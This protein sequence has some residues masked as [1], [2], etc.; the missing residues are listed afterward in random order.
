MKRFFL[1]TAFIL[2]GNIVFAQNTKISILDH[3]TA[4]VSYKHSL[5]STDM[6]RTNLVLD[7]YAGYKFKN[8][9]SVGPVLSQNFMLN[10]IEQTYK[11]Q[12][13]LGLGIRY[14]IFELERNNGK[15]SVEPY[16]NLLRDTENNNFTYYDAGVNF[17]LPAA[18][19]CFIGIGI[20]HYFYDNGQKNHFTSY[21][22]IGIRL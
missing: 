6:S 13:C 12:A 22:S 8:K 19:N 9:I 2:L 16:I 20:M 4:N 7:F 18:R 15:A 1:I 5:Y 14:L 11:H 3:L 10:N 17:L 21:L